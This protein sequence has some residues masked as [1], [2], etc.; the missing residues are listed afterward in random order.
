[1]IVR[2]AE[3]G[4]P[5]FQLRRGEEGLSVF[6]SEA[7]APP[8]DDLEILG[9]FRPGSLLVARSAAEIE[10]KGLNIVFVPGASSF[11]IR[12]QQAHHET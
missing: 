7:V 6:L 2:V 3:P 1:M 9:P 8:L 10:A 4:R 5:A 11:P 12:L